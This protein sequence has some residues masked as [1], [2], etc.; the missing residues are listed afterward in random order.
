MELSDNVYLW[1]GG[2]LDQSHMGYSSFPQVLHNW[3][4]KVNCIYYPVSEIVHIKYLLLLEK[5]TYE[6]VA[7]SV[8]INH[9]TDAT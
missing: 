1:Y 2:L 9:T 5:V 8:V 3:C 6:M 4:N 7:L